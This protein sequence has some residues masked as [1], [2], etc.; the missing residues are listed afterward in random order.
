[1]SEIQ[2]DTREQT[3][4]LI[5]EAFEDA[6]EKE[7][8]DS[9]RRFV[10]VESSESTPVSA[11]QEAEATTEDRATQPKQPN[12]ARRRAIATGAGVVIASAA[13]VGIAGAVAAADGPQ[14]PEFSKETTTYTVQPGDG[15]YNVVESIPGINTVDEREAI[16][17]VKA[18]PANIDALKDGLQP[19]ESIE[20]PLSINGVTSSENK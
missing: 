2:T 8:G 12:Y 10:D 11:P 19:G 15:L 14:A 17:H 7:L 16:D 3:S 20:V 4:P 9:S 13:T 6:F 5:D 1:M 18:D